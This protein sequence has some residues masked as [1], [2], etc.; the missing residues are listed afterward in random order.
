M[1]FNPELSTN[2]AIF[3]SLLAAFMWGSWFVSLKYLGNYPLSGF[4]ITLF[5]TS[6]ILVW[7]VALIL[8]GPALFNNLSGV[9]NTDPSRILL[10]L[11]CG[12]LYV[13]GMRIG[14]IV[15]KTI[16][17]SLSQPIQSSINVMVGTAVS[18]LVGGVPQNVSIGWIAVAVLFLLGAVAASMLAGRWRT[19]SVSHELNP[20][21]LSYSS[22]DLWRSLGLLVFSS[23][24]IPAYTFGLSYGLKSV[25]QPN[26]MAVMPF[27]T[28]LASGA[29]IG[30]CLTSGLELTLKKQWHLVW[31]AGFK[32]HRWGIISGLAHYG[33]N[34]IHTFATAFLSSV[35][36]WPLGVTSGLWTQAW[37]LIYG[38]FKGSSR[39]T[40]I[41]LFTG[42]GLYLVGAY[43]IAARMH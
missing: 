12:V 42:L 29:F 41:A 3:M 1:N 24:F 21:G 35:V 37:G 19:Q 9:W 4:Y 15:L 7:G 36:S 8:D 31:N 30:A 38:E 13:V 32:I 34:I 17:L 2:I 40:Y 23:L 6:I 27:M 18:A 25:S 20:G 22:R 39:R 28:M 11:L 5:T 16:G 26:G 10:T 14:L 33:G 43:I